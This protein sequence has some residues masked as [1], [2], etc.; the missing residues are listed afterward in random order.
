MLP[1]MLV[2]VYYAVNRQCLRQDTE[3]CEK[4]QRH[5]CRYTRFYSDTI[6][7]GIIHPGGPY[8]L[9]VYE[10]SD[11]VM[12]LKSGMLVIRDVLVQK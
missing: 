2:M 8:I 4:C 10:K 1:F 7:K 11:P 5:E 6:E 9:R 12:P 3:R